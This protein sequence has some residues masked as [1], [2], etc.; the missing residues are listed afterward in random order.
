MKEFEPPEAEPRDAIRPRSCCACFEL[1][2]FRSLGRA[3][4]WSLAGLLDGPD[5]L[6]VRDHPAAE[7]GEDPASLDRR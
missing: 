4:A 2:R 6:D 7:R 1:S 3:A 5:L